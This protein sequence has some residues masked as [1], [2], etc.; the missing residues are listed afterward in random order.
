MIIFRS[1]TK[2]D[3]DLVKN[4]LIQAY[5]D[6]NQ[7]RGITYLAFDNDNLIGVTKVRENK[8]RWYL[9]F[10]YIAEEE[11]KKGFGDG[12]FR[13][14]VNKLRNQNIKSL[15]FNS[16][17]N[18]LINKGFYYNNDNELELDIDRFFSTSNCG[19]CGG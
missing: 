8:N 3:Y 4:F 11:R 7:E 16:N 5:M 17:S 12:L 1:Y 10:I 14:I 2:N 18:Y 13:S 15:F 9:D 6:F 19:S